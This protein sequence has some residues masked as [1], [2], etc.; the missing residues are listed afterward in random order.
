M[1]ASLSKIHEL[2]L[3]RTSAQSKK[4]IGSTYWKV[5]YT[6]VDV[7]ELLNESTRFEDMKNITGSYVFA[8]IATNTVVKDENN[9]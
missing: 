9:K 8:A 6:E 3:I 7:A 1:S 4:K 2:N 5:S